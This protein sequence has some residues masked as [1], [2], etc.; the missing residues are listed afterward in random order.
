MPITIILIAVTALV[1]FKGFS[2]P[3]IINKMILNPYKVHNN[4]EWW[5]MFSSGLIHAN[6]NHLLM[7]MLV[8]FFFGFAVEAKYAAEFGSSMG[9][10][11]YFTLYVLGIAVASVKDTIT[12]KDNYSYNALGASGATSAVL[13]AFILFEPFSTLLLYFV[14]PIP[15]I[16]LGIGYLWYS[17]YMAKRNV[18]NIGHNAHF[19]GAIFGLVFTVFL[20]PEIGLRFI[21]TVSTYLSNLFT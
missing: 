3:S 9:D 5:R 12:M 8:L 16:L 6:T 21:E 1:S 7:N 2:D 11:Y 13:F 10:I 19:Y 18:D 15:A 4:K 17:S 14:L 20:K